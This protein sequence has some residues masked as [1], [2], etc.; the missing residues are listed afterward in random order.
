MPNMR[1]DPDAVLE[2]KFDLKA[3]TNGSGTEDYLQDG[4]TI[5]SHTVTVD[6]G[7]T[8]DSD[9]ITD[10]NTSVTVWLSGGTAGQAYTVLLN[11]TTS[12][13]RTDD[14]IIVVYVNEKIN[15]V[16]EDGTGKTN[17]NSYASES[18]LSDYAYRRGVTVTADYSQLLIQAMDSI[19]QQNFKGDKATEAQA[20]QWPR[21]GVMLDGYYV[22]HDAIPDL[23]KEAQ[24]ETCLAIDG[25]N[26]P[27][28]NVPR[29]TKREKVAD[30]E[31]EYMDGAA[32][33]VY[34]Q[35]I[36]NKLSKLL[37]G[38]GGFRVIRV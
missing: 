37:K 7:L 17:S 2:Y 3:L 18:E 15:V 19:E 24:L 30:I 35:A 9:S 10:T 34:V 31:V 16:V 23:L 6:S 12:D 8:K 33:L 4:E 28:A 26:N 5:S 21:V 36:D 20:L 29:G 13:A 22:D 14:K 25:G 27:L 32:D 11:F 1:K 38:G